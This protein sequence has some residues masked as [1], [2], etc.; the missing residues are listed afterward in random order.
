MNS[1]SPA[2][3]SFPSVVLM[4]I[5]CDRNAKQSALALMFREL[6]PGLLKSRVVFNRGEHVDT[7][8][9]PECVAG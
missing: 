1:L 8:C 4:A 2:C 9:V 6:S 7:L 3:H 5:A